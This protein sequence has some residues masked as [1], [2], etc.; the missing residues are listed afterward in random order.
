MQPSASDT[1]QIVEIEPIPF[2]TGKKTRRLKLPRGLKR[3]I[4]LAAIVLGTI[5]GAGYWFW[6]TSRQV[7]FEIEPRPDVIA[8]RGTLVAPKWKQFFLLLPGGHTLEAK[9]HGYHP[10]IQPFTVTGDRRQT[11]RFAMEKL[12]GLVTIQAHEQNNKS[13]NIEK[14][15]VFIDGKESAINPF[16]N[17]EINAGRHMVEIQASNYLN[18]KTHIQIEGGGLSQT[19]AFG[20]TPDWANV[21]I[22]SIPDGA[23]VQINGQSKGITPASLK[24]PQGKYT[25]SL[26]ADNYKPWKTQFM[27]TPN[28][29]VILEN[30]QLEKPEG[31]LV[32]ETNPS[33]AEVTLDRTVSGNT[34]LK[35]SIAPQKRHVI[36]IA[37]PGYEE[38]VQ[39]IEITSDEVKTVSLDLVPVEG[40]VNFIV[41]PEDAEISVDGKSQGQAKRELRLPAVEH[42]IEI[43]KS[44][45]ETWR[46]KITP[47]PGYPQEVKVALTRQ[48]EMAKQEKP[49]ATATK[50]E[51]VGPAI[52]AANGYRLRQIPPGSFTMGSSR[53][54]Q[55]RRSNETLRNV[56]LK[57]PFYVGEREVTNR[58]FL[59]FSLSHSSGVFKGNNLSE[60]NQPVV[61]VTWDEAA[62]FCNWL[63]AQE[64]GLTPSYLE[65][66]G[67]VIPANSIGTGYRL[68]TEAEWEYAAR[69]QTVGQTLKYTGGNS[70]PPEPESVNIADKT[71]QDVLTYYLD[72]YSDSYPVSSDAGSFKPDSLGLYD[73]GGN[74]AEWVHDSYTIYS[75]V[76][77]KTYVDPTGPGSASKLHVIRGSSWKHA[78]IS[79]LRS[80]FRDYGNEKRPDLGFRICRYAQ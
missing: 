22:S 8:L 60:P 16:K 15:R 68:C 72:D 59:A 9:K 21:S 73:M 4:I 56:T 1:P 6:N 54:E 74:V 80:A 27:V 63:S 50:I 66:S 48:T 32:I 65:Q 76:A 51:T 3:F 17:V 33:D 31:W 14:N 42:E 25:L 7:A 77:D 57:R 44:G 45:Y 61:Q 10:L 34:P 64:D 30:I 40:I 46:T 36:N 26:H 67:S 35:L 11:L 75:S 49:I 24:L 79:E 62:R 55:G 39:E 13:L 2:R 29:P 47:H 70:F 28:K 5:T 53:R 52:Q 20:L 41:E 58:E 19:F 18:F 69:Y 12:P 71:S 78:S 43:S 37:K 38:V 23:E